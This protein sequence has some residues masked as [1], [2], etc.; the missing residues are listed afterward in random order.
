MLVSINDENINEVVD[1]LSKLVKSIEPDRFLDPE[2]YP[3]TS[4]SRRTVFQYFLVMVAMDHRLSRPGRPY[5]GYVEGKLYHGADLLYRLGAKKLKEDLDFF[6]PRRL[7]TISI[8]DVKEWLTLHNDKASPPDPDIRAELLKDLGVK[9]LKLYD[10]DPILLLTE[11][12]GFL[13]NRGSGLIEILKVFKAYNDPVEKKAYLLAKFIER[14]EVMSFLD[15]QNKEVPVDNHLVR[16]ALRL[17]LVDVDSTFLEKI[18]YGIEVSEDED[19]LLR[20]ATR[21]AYKK[22]ISKVGV[23]PFVLDDFLWN[24]GRKVCRRESPV[25]K[26]GEGCPLAP[27]CRANS[28]PLYM[29]PE[30]KYL[31]TWW[32]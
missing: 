23:D 21:T 22:L 16:I 3:P 8:K 25:C 18:A 10:G 32:Y 5:E 4:A 20:F 27:T 12:R 29:V 9:L 13:K 31:E 17:G 2:L 1:S 19:V 30:H 15:P 6:E 7:A 28:N 14:R 11:S 24:F 26:S